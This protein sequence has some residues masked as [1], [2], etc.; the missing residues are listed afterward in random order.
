MTELAVVEK[1]P[2]SRRID[3]PDFPTVCQVSYAKG[4]ITDFKRPAVDN[5]DNPFRVESMVKVEIE[6]V[7][8]SDF[9]PLFYH[10]RKQ[11]W[12]TEDHKAQDINQDEKYFENAWMSFRVDDEVKVMLQDGKPFAVVGF[13]DGIPRIGEDVIRAVAQSVAS[14]RMSILE[15]YDGDQGPDGL[16]LG[17]TLEAELI[18]EK[19]SDFKQ[20][21]TLYKTASFSLVSTYKSDVG[22]NSFLKW[23]RLYTTFW[24]VVSGSNTFLETKEKDLTFLAKVGPILYYIKIGIG[25]Y[26]TRDI[27]ENYTT[28][29]PSENSSPAGTCVTAT[30]Q[31]LMP[32]GP[33][34]T[35]DTCPGELAYL[36][37][38]IAAE[39]AKFPQTFERPNA[40][41]TKTTLWAALYT[42]E[43]YENTKA[44]P[45]DPYG[46][47]PDNFKLQNI[48]QEDLPYLQ[49]INFGKALTSGGDIKLYTRPHTKEELQAAG[50]WPG[51]T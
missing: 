29:G 2:D 21:A 19:E 15:K 47:P 46:P 32:P 44:N 10:P 28:G 9:I 1:Y 35:V 48:Q 4:K 20:L 42:K 17:L 3:H 45:P 6:G 12:D 38:L 34:G 37:N 23:N 33:P 11:Y 8:E 26:A 22:E 18:N 50:F 16:D 31:Q 39:N 43:L 5:P 13:L 24:E 49:R 27:I 7:G 40:F 25:G 51:A 30:S 14:A 41:A 36:Q